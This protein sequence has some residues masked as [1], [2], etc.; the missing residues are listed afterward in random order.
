MDAAT[1]IVLQPTGRSKPVRPRRRWCS[2]ASSPSCAALMRSAAS[3]DTTIVRPWTAWPSEAARIRLSFFVGSSPCSRISLRCRPLVSIRSVPPLGSATGCADV[4]AVG[5]P[6]LLDG[7]DHRPGGPS[8]VVEAGLVL[9]E[10]LHHHQGDHGVG[11]GKG[12]DRVGIRDEHR[13][14]EHHPGGGRVG[15]A[16]ARLVGQQIGQRTPNRWWKGR[17]STGRQCLASGRAGVGCSRG[18][19]GG[20]GSVEGPMRRATALLVLVLLVLSSCGGD[21]DAVGT[22][23]SSTSS[24]TSSSST[25]STTVGADP[26]TTPTKPAGQGDDPAGPS[27]P[28]SSG[29]IR[30]SVGGGFSPYGA[31]FAAVPT[32]VLADGTAFTGGATTMQYPGPAISPVSTGRLSSTQVAS[33]LDA[34]KAAG[35]D[36]EA[37]LRPARHHRCRHHHDHRRPRRQDLHRRGLRPRLRGRHRG[38]LGRAAGGRGRRCPCSSAR[39]A[40]R[41]LPPPPAPSRPPRTRCSPRPRS[42]RPAT[43]TRSPTPSTGRSAPSRW[44]R[45]AC[46]DLTGADADAFRGALDEGVADHRVAE[47]REGL[48]GDR[49]RDPAG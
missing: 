49:S 37:R 8:D 17:S 19:L 32:L 24:S 27:T 28:A 3:F 25:T 48:A 14:V 36:D 15:R 31:D 43:R 2:I 16:G 9:I 12:R 21:D 11:P 13:S 42:P 40:T 30:I 39:W 34:A 33:L 45:V 44:S 46:R 18:N 6:Q 4:A 29:V 10:L 20:L 47:R 5:D 7:P 38:P 35:L 41:C 26:T 23:S 1:S 22:D